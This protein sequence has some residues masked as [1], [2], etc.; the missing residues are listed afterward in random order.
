M[1][2]AA[3]KCVKVFRI[4]I[5]V[6][7]ENVIET[8]A[9]TIQSNR[10]IKSGKVCTHHWHIESSKHNDGQCLDAPFFVFL[11]KNKEKATPLLG[12]I[13]VSA[14]SVRFSFDIFNHG[15][16]SKED[17]L[18]KCKQRPNL[19]HIHLLFYFP[20]FFLSYSYQ[21]DAFVASFRRLPDVFYLH[22]T[23]SFCICLISLFI[24]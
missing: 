24:C 13:S 15:V 12:I 22:Y 7:N 17:R 23:L 1:F 2:R 16:D 9:K 20:L 18:A 19:I 14:F 5:F 10:F 4:P 3:A 11:K 8:T 6:S 21:L